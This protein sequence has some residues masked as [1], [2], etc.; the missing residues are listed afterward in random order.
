MKNVNEREAREEFISLCIMYTKNKSL[1][2]KANV[3]QK[4]YTLQEGEN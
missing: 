1:V 2:N 4:L 3:V